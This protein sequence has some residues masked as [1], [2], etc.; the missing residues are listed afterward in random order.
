MRLCLQIIASQAT[1]GRSFIRAISY[2]CDEIYVLELCST[3]GAMISIQS[4]PHPSAFAASQKMLADQYATGRKT[5]QAISSGC[6]WQ[7]SR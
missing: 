5:M 4:K 6:D 1:T 7:D 3:I 2:N